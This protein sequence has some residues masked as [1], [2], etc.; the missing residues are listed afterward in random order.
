MTDSDRET[1]LTNVAQ[2]RVRE[3]NDIVRKSAVPWTEYY[4]YRD[5]DEAWYKT[6]RSE[7]AQ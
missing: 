5:Y 2:S 3:L 1:F 6:Y 7:S 4:A